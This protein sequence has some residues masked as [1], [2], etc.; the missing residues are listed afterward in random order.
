M[1][2]SVRLHPLISGEIRLR[3]MH[4]RPPRRGPG[5]LPRALLGSLARK[6]HW[7]PV[8]AFLVEHPSEGP[9][10]IDAG[11][12]PSV[13][14]DPAKTLGFFFGKIAMQHR[15]AERSLVEQVSDRGIDPAEVALVV[16]THLHNDHASGTGQWPQATFL[17]DRRERAAAQ[18]GAGPYVKDHLA[19]IGRWR[20]IDYDDAESFGSF[21]QTIDLFQDG[22]VRLISS[23]G[24]SLGHQSVL[25]RLHHRY[26]LICGDSAMSTRELREPIIDGIVVD[27]DAYLRSGDEARRF[28]RAHPDTLAIPSHDRKAIADLQHTVG[29][30]TALSP[31]SNDG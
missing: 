9:F 17:V 3:V 10:L 5:K 18:R 7:Y 26:A 1:T 21:A 2:A 24:H 23:P 28:I 14:S 27:Q 20:E 16:M 8:P 29:L 15:L 22:S 30:P 6:A 12:D 13:A 11:Y 31:S 19:K 25:L 4:P